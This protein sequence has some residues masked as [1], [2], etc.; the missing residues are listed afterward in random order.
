M[1]EEQVKKLPVYQC[2]KQVRALKIKKMEPTEHG[3]IITPADPNLDPF[4]VNS[5]YI[6]KHVPQ[7][8]GYFVLYADGYESF[9]PAKAFEEGYS[10][11]KEG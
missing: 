11:I 4:F 9:S 7:A 3:E 5:A 2:H 6:K 1:E 8:G 10:L